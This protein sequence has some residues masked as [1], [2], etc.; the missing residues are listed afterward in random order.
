MALLLHGD[1]ARPRSTASCA[2]HRATV[3]LDSA[4]RTRFFLRRRTEP[5][6]EQ[7][8]HVVAHELDVARAERDHQVAGLRLLVEPLR[9]VL[10]ARHVMDVLVPRLARAACTSASL[11]MPSIGFSPA[12]K[13]SQITTLSASWNA[14]GELG[15]LIARAREAVRL[16]RGDTRRPPKLDF[17]PP[18]SVARDLGRVV[19]EV[20]DD[21]DAAD[22]AAH[23][24]PPR[25]ALELRERL[26][27]RLE[28]DRPG[29]RRPR[30]RRAR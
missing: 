28:R 17:A 30:A 25:D 29:S 7:L 12:A 1:R 14:R 16:E 15:P 9:E 10:A 19:A 18:D 6:L 8:D 20:V 27:V 21:G 24:E 3:A 26:D 22:L 23:R 11:V 13:M 4:T 5:L 2:L